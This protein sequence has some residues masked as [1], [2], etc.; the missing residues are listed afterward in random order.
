MTILLPL[1]L[2]CHRLNAFDGDAWTLDAEGAQGD[3]Q[4][5]AAAGVN[6]PSDISWRTTAWSAGGEDVGSVKSAKRAG[7][8]VAAGWCSMNR[9]ET[10][11]QRVRASGDSE[12]AAWVDLS[13]EEKE[14]LKEPKKKTKECA[15]IPCCQKRDTDSGETP[16]CG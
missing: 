10:V 12:T 9:E 3:I 5:G 2:A 13:A 4:V 8:G 7:E 15:K 14:S 16:R 1:S 11:R 6:E